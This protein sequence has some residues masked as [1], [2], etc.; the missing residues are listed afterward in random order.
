MQ[1][2]KKKVRKRKLKKHLQ[3]KEK[4]L[5]RKIINM[6][7]LNPALLRPTILKK[8]CRR[9]LEKICGENFHQNSVRLYIKPD[10]R[11]I[12]TRDVALFDKVARYHEIKE[13]KNK[14][15]LIYPIRILHTES[16]SEILI[17]WTV[18]LNHEQ[19]GKFLDHYGGN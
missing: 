3:R 1:S 7:Q 2:R 15:D 10:E 4:N 18:S 13:I 5:R 19:R 9:H 17:P 16:S 12:K 14:S 8:E 11:K 6:T